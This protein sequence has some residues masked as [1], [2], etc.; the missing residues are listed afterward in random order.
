[1]F[2]VIINLKNDYMYALLPIHF[3]LYLTNTG[4]TAT[5]LY[6]VVVCILIFYLQAR[7]EVLTITTVQLSTPQKKKLSSGGGMGEREE[8]KKRKKRKNKKTRRR[9][10]NKERKF[11]PQQLNP[12]W[13]SGKYI[14]KL[15]YFLDQIARGLFSSSLPFGSKVFEGAS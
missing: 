7:C 12:Y 1:M 9:R 14:S 3:S 15:P 2:L 8:K 10:G 4:V 13:T 6:Y 11:P 5:P